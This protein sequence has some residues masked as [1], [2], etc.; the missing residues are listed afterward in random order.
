M[1]LHRMGVLERAAPA[2]VAPENTVAPT[3]SG[4]TAVGSTLTVDR[5]TWSGSPTTYT[6]RWARDGV[7]IPGATSITYVTTDDDLAAAIRCDVTGTNAL[8]SATAT[9]SNAIAVTEP[10][11]ESSPNFEHTVFL[12][13]FR[14]L[15]AQGVRSG[16]T[17]ILDHSGRHTFDLP[18]G[19]FLTADGYVNPGGGGFAIPA[20][21]DFYAEA[22]D[23]PY[24]MEVI[25][26]FD[27]GTPSASARILLID[28]SVGRGYKADGSNPQFARELAVW[29]SR[30]V[31]QNKL[32]H[33]YGEVTD[34][35]R[36]YCTGSDYA[37]VTADDFPWGSTAASLLCC[38]AQGTYHALRICKGGNSGY[39][40]G[41]TPPGADGSAPVPDGFLGP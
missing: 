2:T 21:P 15:Y 8:G 3:I 29:S 32:Y 5:G 36:F 17:G 18:A 25:M 41:G 1:I 38:Y 7:D 39:M 30:S 12:I 27:Q 22:A 10:A 35:T 28:T 33:G 9:S 11:W 16:D 13:D 23:V 20:S 34:K 40:N 31:G 24:L 4:A 19:D 6:Y 26:N 37:V 14:Q